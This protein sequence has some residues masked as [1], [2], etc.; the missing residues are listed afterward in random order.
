MNRHEKIAWFSLAVIGSSGLL[1]LVLFFTLKASFPIA[2]SL[3]ISSAAFAVCGFLGFSQTL[4]RKEEYPE[5]STTRFYDPEMDER[6]MQIYRR[7][8]SHGFAAFWLALVFLAMGAWM[9]LRWKNGF[10]GPVIIP[11]DVDFLPLMLYPGFLLV[12]F[13]QYSSIILQHRSGSMYGGSIEG[14]IVPGRRSLIFSFIILPVFLLISVFAAVQGQLLFAFQFATISFGSTAMSLRELRRMQGFA[15]SENE[16]RTYII[17]GRIFNTIFTLL[18]A[19][20]L[21]TF[22]WSYIALNTFRGTSLFI[23]LFITLMFQRT[24]LSDLIRHFKGHRHEKA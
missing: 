14:D 11:L 7:A 2:L 17:L 15:G 9:Y 22:I 20:L 24:V 1:F 16:M 21:G 18:Y 5:G 4:F 10:E 8:T 12:R 6:D 13:V 23:L 19:G 3:K